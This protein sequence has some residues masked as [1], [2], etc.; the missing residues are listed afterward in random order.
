MMIT[1]MMMM[2]MTDMRPMNSNNGTKQR[3]K[4]THDESKETIVISLT[5]K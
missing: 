2:T 1:M 4:F 3:S 5:G